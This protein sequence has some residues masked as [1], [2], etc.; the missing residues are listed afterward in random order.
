MKSL[1]F[2][3]ALV[4]AFTNIIA[5]KKVYQCTEDKTIALTVSF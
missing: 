2:Y 4:I 1:S 3:I 5:A